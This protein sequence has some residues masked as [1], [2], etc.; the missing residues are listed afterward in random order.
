MVVNDTLRLGR[1]RGVRVGMNWT[2]V[3]MAAFLAVALAESRLPYDAPGYTSTAYWAAGVVTAVALLLGVLLHELGHALVARRAG[4][5][6]DGIT[7]WFMG[8]ITRIEGD[9]SSPGAE[10]RIS[11]V[12]PL[13]SLVLGGALW[14]FSIGLAHLSI[15]PLV[16]E[17]MGWLGIINVALAA[18]NLLPGAPLDGGRVL[19]AAVWAITRDR[20]R[21]TRVASGAGAG[22]GALLVAGGL[23]EFARGDGVDGALLAVLG[24]FMF[25]SARSEEQ[26][27]NVHRLLEGVRIGDMMRPVRAAPG[28]LTVDALLASYADVPGAVLMLEQWG[29]GFSGIVSLD[30]LGAVPFQQRHLVRG[31]DLAVPVSAAAGAS[32]ADDVIDALTTGGGPGVLLVIDGGHT[33]GAVLPADIDGWLHR[34]SPAPA[35]IH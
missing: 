10:L 7:L 3:A 32:P 22:L 27:A 21:A 16:L 19:H 29:G 15:S 2:L 20:W 18:F 34:R 28:W 25:T 26:V 9:A 24:W 11:G 8:G 4:L 33:V 35:G 23:V 30:A 12:G 5:R 1:I 17:A 13:V 31:S 14:G 6:V